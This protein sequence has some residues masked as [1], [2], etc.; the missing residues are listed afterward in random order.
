MTA[1]VAILN[2]GAVAIAA[3]SAVTAG[4]QD[5]KIYNTANKV[6]ALSTLEPVA[7]MIYGLGSFGAIPWDT[8]VKEY[9]RK[10]GPTSY[11]TVAEYATDFI[12]YIRE[13][14][15]YIPET[16]QQEF[17]AT[18]AQWELGG[19]RSLM[20]QQ[21]DQTSAE[22]EVSSRPDKEAVL[23]Q[24][25]EDRTAYLTQIERV[26]NLD[27]DHVARELQSA[28]EDWPTF[29]KKA[30]GLTSVS[31]ETIDMAAAMV[32]LSLQIAG[33]SPWS[34]GVVVAG[35]GSEQLF[36]ALEHYSIDGVIANI[37]RTRILDS[38]EIGRDSTALIIPF[39]QKDMV[40]TFMDGVHPGYR[41]AIDEFVDESIGLFTQHFAEQVKDC[42]APDAY[43][44]LLDQMQEARSQTTA[45]FQKRL[46]IL[47]QENSS[48]PIM[49]TVEILPKE[50]LAEMA[51]ALVNL[52][53]FRQR[54]TP[55]METVGGP[56]D[57]AIISKGDGLVWI[58]RKHYFTPELNFRYFERDRSFRLQGESE[59]SR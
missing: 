48:E 32:T 46:G 49:S 20:Q 57:V 58:K 44:E 26:N 2:R 6:F 30:L 53:S 54:V 3:D 17:V 24:L 42:V 25:V 23:T 37:L 50:E 39:A 34:S 18:V 56:I 7:V 36:P 27:S 28:I 51:E 11:A 9:R 15:R 5:P 47:L 13:L 4:G 43:E 40:M 1:E 35:F 33:E 16:S 29:T 59:E 12:N 45:N 10:L 38:V 52:S 41:R 14:T 8:I 55:E 22:D 19:L 31:T 21:L